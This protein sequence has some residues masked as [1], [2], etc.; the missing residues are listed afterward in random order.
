MK[1]NKFQNREIRTE[2]QDKSL[3]KNEKS[4]NSQIRTNFEIYPQLIEN[5]KLTRRYSFDD[6]GGGYSGL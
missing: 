4:Q 5:N 6:N 3:S 2:N 1:E